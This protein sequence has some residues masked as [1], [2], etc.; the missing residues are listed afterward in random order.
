[1]AGCGFLMVSLWWI[2][3]W[4]W[5]FDGRFLG[6][7]KYAMISGFIFD[8]CLFWKPSGSFEVLRG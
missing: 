2:A 3:W 1:M 6:A 7:E 8:G 4:M 5:C